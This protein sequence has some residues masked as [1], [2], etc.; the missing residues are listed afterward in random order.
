MNQLIAK[1][2]LFSSCAVLC[3]KVTVSF[4]DDY[5]VASEEKDLDG[6]PLSESTK[7]AVQTE[8]PQSPNTQGETAPA[9]Q[10]DKVSEMVDLLIE[11]SKKQ[12]PVEEQPAISLPWQE[13]LPDSNNAQQECAEDDQEDEYLD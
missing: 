3:G 10:T 6:G 9:S 8:K 5:G 13:V 2:L 1:R 11:R 12:L 7:S 4:G